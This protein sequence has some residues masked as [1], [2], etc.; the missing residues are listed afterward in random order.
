MSKNL[1]VP[2]FRPIILGALPHDRLGQVLNTIITPG[3]VHFTIPAQKHAF[4]RHPKDFHT[5]FPYLSQAVFRPTY[6]GQSPHHIGQ[7]IEVVLE[8]PGDGM[9]VLV[10]ITVTSSDG[11]VYYVKSTY[12][13]DN[14]KIY[15]RLRKGHLFNF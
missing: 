13:I 4:K 12:L 9:N 6:L 14:I 1:P 11:G 5:C 15:S 10:A 7:G 8:V 3:D 2:N